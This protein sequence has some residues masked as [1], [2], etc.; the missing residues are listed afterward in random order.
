MERDGDATVRVVV[1]VPG[2]E[3][4]TWRGVA[5]GDVKV[6]VPVTLDEGT[7]VL[8]VLQVYASGATENWKP[9]VVATSARNDAR[10]RVVI[11]VVVAAALAAWF[12]LR[13]RR[14]R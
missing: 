11:L 8:P 4:V 2:A 12:V 5:A 14:Q 10:D 1:R 9:E 7:H 6:N 3:P 13:R